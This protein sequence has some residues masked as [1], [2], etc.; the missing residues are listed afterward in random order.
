MVE[1]G[2]RW[3]AD[4]L[5]AGG[6]EIFF[7]RWKLDC[8]F[9]SRKTG[10]RAS[11]ALPKRFRNASALLP[12]FVLRKS[13]GNRGDNREDSK[14]FWLRKSRNTDLVFSSSKTQKMLAAH[15]RFV[16]FPFLLLVPGN[17]KSIENCRGFFPFSVCG[18]PRK[19][20]RSTIRLL[21]VHTLSANAE[22]VF[23]DGSVN[24]QRANCGVLP[25]KYASL[26]EARPRS[27]AS[28][29]RGTFAPR[30]GNEASYR[31]YS[32]MSRG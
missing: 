22:S 29:R 13:E 31:L 6:C 26:G 28:P 7:L 2:L 11:E 30:A 12:V 5:V 27:R 10:F 17:P 1:T 32:G 8:G 19:L 4:G 3:A 15:F 25:Q 18:V 24:C 9:S 16:S 23:V 20:S 21:A 14:K